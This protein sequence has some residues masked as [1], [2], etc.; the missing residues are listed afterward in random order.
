M[1]GAELSLAGVSKSFGGLM[2]IDHLEFTV[3]RGSRTAL[4]GPNGAGK[5][6]VFNLVSGVY[7]IDDGT[8]SLDGR[9]ISAV[10]PSRRIRHGI[11]RSFQNIRLMPHLSTLENVMLGEHWRR[12]AFSFA[13]GHRAVEAAKSVLADAGLQTYPG[14]VVANL[15]YGIQKRIEV[16]RALL[17]E[18][19]ILM[20][21]EP[22][23]GLN[24]AETDDLRALLERVSARGITLL[25]VEHDMHF[26]RQLCDH[27]V[28][29]NF[30]Q[31]I[32][33][34]TPEEVHRAPA[35]IEAYLGTDTPPS[36]ARPASSVG[37]P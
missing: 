10:S 18:P 30:G 7:P 20:L 8:I 12:P 13:R 15:P 24:S 28:V 32:F 26:V 3:R 27:V 23:A 11:S 22:A 31:L 25:V 37:A 14:Q 1:S 33:E 21:D 9:D 2:V 17:A 6:T 16:V 29:L 4:I 35:V 34:G 19:K 5:T 36:I